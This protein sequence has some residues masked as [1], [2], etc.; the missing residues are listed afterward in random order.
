[1]NHGE[2]GVNHLGAL[3]GLPKFAVVQYG[4]RLKLTVFGKHK[5]KT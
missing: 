2:L 5:G 1:M 4:A 3:F